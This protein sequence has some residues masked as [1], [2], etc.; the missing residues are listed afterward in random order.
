MHAIDDSSWIAHICHYGQIWCCV[1]LIAPADGLQVVVAV[2]DDATE[3]GPVRQAA[4]AIVLYKGR[5][6]GTLERS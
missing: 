4:P 2:L 1:A 5:S 3:G 6:L